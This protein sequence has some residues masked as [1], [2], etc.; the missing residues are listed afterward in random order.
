MILKDIVILC[1]GKGT[2]LGDIT[3]Y[4]PKPLLK[5]YNIEFIKY[6]IQF[7]SKLGTENIYL[8]AGYRGKLFKKKFD[9]KIYNI[10][11]V[12]VLIE[13]RPL[14]TGGALALLRKKI[15][16][17][18][19]LINGDSINNF[20][21][22]LIQKKI[23]KI[24]KMFLIENFNYKSNKKLISLNI[25]KNIIV[26]KN[27]K[28]MNSGI[29][30]L[31]SKIL[32]SVKKKYMSLENDI[33]PDL[34]KKKMIEGEILKSNFIDIGTK[35]NFYK[36]KNFLKKNFYKPAIFLDR[37]GVI[38]YDYGYVHRYKNF[39]YKPGVIQALKLLNEKNFYIFIITNQ[40][41]IGRGYYNIDDFYLLHQ[42]LAQFLSKKK[43]YID[44][45]KFCP[46]HPIHGK[47]KYKRKCSCRKPGN[48]MIEQLK[49]DWLININRSF[50]IGDKPSDQK[51]AEKSNIKFFYAEK[52][53]Y[54]QVKNIIS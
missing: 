45:I 38:N 5:F 54:T 24:V 20:D 13:N 8:L 9:E 30:L 37:D 14:G 22:S 15:N 36:T 50:M 35:K 31:N 2:R 33:L 49:A 46:H 47:G 7:F 53:L 27:S 11:K 39:H 48:Q 40:S 10:T 6:L 19:L 44:D 26:F 41:G 29:Y 21:I 17:N 51:A 34:I 4:T 3:K 25:K 42:K 52:N 43:I 18:F 12:S 16:K 1:G 32:N 23:K 28:L